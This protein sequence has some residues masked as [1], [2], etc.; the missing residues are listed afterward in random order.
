V[1]DRAGVIN[2]PL[3]LDHRKASSVTAGD[4]GNAETME[5]RAYASLVY[6]LIDSTVLVCA[7]LARSR[8][9]RKRKALQKWAKAVVHRNGKVLAWIILFTLGV[10]QSN[11]VGCE[12]EVFNR[13]G[14]FRKPASSV[15]RDFKRSP[16]PFRFIPQVIPDFR[17]LR[18][19]KFG[20]F[21]LAGATDAETG[22]GVRL[23]K[24]AP[25]RFVYQLREKLDL[26]KSGVVRDSAAMNGI[27]QSPADIH[28]A[29]RVFDLAGVNDPLTVKK[30]PERVPS[31]CIPDTGL[32]AVLPM[33][34]DVAGYPGSKSGRIARTTDTPFLNGRFIGHSLSFAGIGGIIRAESSRFLNPTTGVQI[35]LAEV[36]KRGA[37]MSPDGCHGARVSGCLTGVKQKE[38]ASRWQPWRKT[39]KNR[40]PKATITPR[41]FD[42]PCETGLSL[43]SVS[44]TPYF[45][46]FV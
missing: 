38:V 7:K 6:G 27:R 4:E 21:F 2:E 28:L 1:N 24:L 46:R 16:H 17:N 9:P 11:A 36:P 13:N 45:G 3:S 43:T 20:L 44:Q 41:G 25:N 35:A 37:D 22:E 10:P 30:R 23:G 19:S 29:M 32:P 40:P 14:A 31:C 5:A 15:K 39:R 42:S 8:S 18:V 34:R 12:V 26:Q 33:G